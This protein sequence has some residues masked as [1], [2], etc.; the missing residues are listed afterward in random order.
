MR[1]LAHSIKQTRGNS[2]D[3]SFPVYVLDPDANAETVLYPSDQAT[4]NSLGEPD[5]GIEAAA[6]ASVP[7]PGPVS[8]KAPHADEQVRNASFTGQD[9]R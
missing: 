1:A 3:D 5:T 9:K 6:T 2:A 4:G 8:S 7:K